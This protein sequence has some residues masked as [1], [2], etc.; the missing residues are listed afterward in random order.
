MTRPYG[1]S[2]EAFIRWLEATTPVDPTREAL[3]Q[4]LLNDA[5]PI[6]AMPKGSLFLTIGQM[7]TIRLRHSLPFWPFTRTEKQRV[8]RVEEWKA[9]LEN[10]ST[11]TLA[12]GNRNAKH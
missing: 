5:T 7:V 10:G 12:F 11:I 8:V 3:I 2:N 1:H 6:D 9:T 4:H